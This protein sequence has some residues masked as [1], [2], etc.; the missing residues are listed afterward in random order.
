MGH[1]AI[2]EAARYIRASDKLAAA[3]SPM[4]T[5][6]WVANYFSVEER[7]I[8]RWIRNGLI[9]SKRIGRLHRFHMADIERMAQAPVSESSDDDL[10]DAHISSIVKAAPVKP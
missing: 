6:Q 2:D 4:L 9:R 3:S 1:R 7:T 5:L 10:L 8:H